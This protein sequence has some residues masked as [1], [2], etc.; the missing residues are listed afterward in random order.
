MSCCDGWIPMEGRGTKFF[1]LLY[2][3][4][5]LF[6]F[7]LSRQNKFITHVQILRLVKSCIFNNFR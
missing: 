6:L 5:F 7:P 1:F 3:S 2:I 4:V